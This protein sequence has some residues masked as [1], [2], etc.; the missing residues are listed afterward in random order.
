MAVSSLIESTPVTETP[1]VEAAALDPLGFLAGRHYTCY[2]GKSVEGTMLCQDC[3]D[4]MV[5]RLGRFVRLDR[6]PFTKI[7]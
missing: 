6:A 3:A 5:E 1:L 7:G 2:C 4:E